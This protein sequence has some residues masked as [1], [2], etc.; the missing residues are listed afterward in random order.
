MRIKRGILN[1]PSTALYP[2]VN[3]M[4]RIL[5]H[6]A[7]AVVDDSLLGSTTNGLR[8]VSSVNSSCFS[9]LPQRNPLGMRSIKS[10][11]EAN[12]HLKH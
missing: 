8:P 2:V 10:H 7:A 11:F 9:Y 5:R 6:R 12:R 3:R 1:S 4:C